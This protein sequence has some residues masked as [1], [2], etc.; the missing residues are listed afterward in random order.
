MADEEKKNGHDRLAQVLKV[1]VEMR[2]TPE[3]V[4]TSINGNGPPDACINALAQGIVAAARI[5]WAKSETSL[6]TPVSGAL[7]P[8]RRL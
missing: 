6:V 1:T 7:P 2:M 4:Q 5:G 8:L 3:G